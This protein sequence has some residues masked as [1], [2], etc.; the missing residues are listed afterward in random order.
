M[1]IAVIG[2]HGVGKSS[3]VG[4][5]VKKRP[6][7]VLIPEMAREMLSERHG[8]IGSWFDFQI[9]LLWRKTTSEGELKD[10]KNLISDR[11][12]VDNWAYCFY[13]KA[14]PEKLL[15]VLKEFAVAYSNN[16]YDL[17]IYLPADDFASVKSGNDERAM[18]IDEIVRTLLP[19]LE[20]VVTLKGSLEERLDK[21]LIEC[22]KN[23]QVET[24]G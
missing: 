11:T 24:Y 17:F 10:N 23:D 20:N 6:D 12:A 22:S 14:L 21:L 2:T 5:F 4:E 15:D 9:E 1:K 7:Y 3:L 19:N 13:Y 16:Y 8:D 18:R